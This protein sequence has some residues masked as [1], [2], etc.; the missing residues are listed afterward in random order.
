MLGR[1]VG[2]GGLGRVEN[3]HELLG[4][5]DEGVSAFDG[6]EAHE[7]GDGATRPDSVDVE[8]LA[9]LKIVVEDEIVVAV[10]ERNV[11]RVGRVRDFEEEAVVGPELRARY[12]RDD[13]DHL[14]EDRAVVP[15]HPSVRVVHAL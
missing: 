6:P 2:F 4:G 1:A 5:S 9:E 12:G 13:P 10:G 8:E 7:D 15:A 11:G 3:L 14:E